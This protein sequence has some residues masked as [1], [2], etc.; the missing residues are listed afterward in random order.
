MASYVT[1]KK[2][3]GWMRVFD[4]GDREAARQRAR[5]YYESNKEKCKAQ[6]AQRYLRVRQSASWRVRQCVR[7]K[8]QLA[9][10]RQE[11]MAHYGNK[12]ACCGETAQAFLTLDHT[13]GGGRQHRKGGCGDKPFVVLAMVHTARFPTRISRAVH[14]LQFR[15]R[16]NRGLPPPGE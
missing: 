9:A 1:P 2:N 5:A 16:N 3:T 4:G 8:E 10:T 7:Q 15:N 13:N 12:C 11:V 14:E 6:A